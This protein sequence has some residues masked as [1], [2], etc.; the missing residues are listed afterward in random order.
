MKLIINKNQI[1][2]TAEQFLRRAG[3]AYIRERVRGKE[4]FVRRLGSGFYP[5][6]HLYADDRGER[7]IFDL[8]LDQKQAS[9]AGTRMHNAEHDSEVVEK[10]I[11]RLKNII[12][13]GGA[14][15]ATDAEADSRDSDILGRIGHRQLPPDSE[16]TKKP[17]WWQRLFS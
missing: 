9:Y 10:E 13:P 1:D 16:P 11:E 5:R 3:Y 12:L 8:H 14:N 7:I 15:T 2:G 6:L 17:G 4:S